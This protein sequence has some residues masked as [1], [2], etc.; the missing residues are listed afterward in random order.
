MLAK[1][2]HLAVFNLNC[3]LFV[4]RHMEDEDFDIRAIGLSYVEK[5]FDIFRDIG[6]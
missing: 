4:D 5:S 3:D 1:D 6:K 2:L